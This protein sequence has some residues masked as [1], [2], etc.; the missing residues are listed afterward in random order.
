[1][2]ECDAPR[3]RRATVPHF[4]PKSCGF[5]LRFAQS[6]HFDERGKCLKKPERNDCHM[7]GYHGYTHGDHYTACLEAKRL[8]DLP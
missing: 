8:T 7:T 2:E 6:I 3:R 5:A 4:S 1:M